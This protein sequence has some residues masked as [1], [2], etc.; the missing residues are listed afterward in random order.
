VAG[1]RAGAAGVGR[2]GT[3]HVGGAALRTQGGY[4][5]AGFTHY[6]AFTPAWYARYPG[7]WFAAGWVAGTAWRAATWASVASYCSYPAAPVYYDYGTTVVYQGDTVYVEGEKVASA[8]EYSQQATKVA[9]AGRAAKPADKEDW[10]A[11]GVFAMVQGEEKTAYH[12]FQLAINK[13]GVLRGNY[14]NAMTDAT[15]PVY[16]SVDKKTQRA[17][18]TVGDRKTPVY[19]TGIA[20]LTQDESTMLVHFGTDRTEQFNLIRIEQPK[21]AK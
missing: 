12:I 18:W 1:G 15:E 16:G 19:E 10:Q 13:Q 9:D 17:A 11:L 14:Y 2:Y 8:A 5:R 21:D 4:V 20:N 3:Y 7:A 6:H